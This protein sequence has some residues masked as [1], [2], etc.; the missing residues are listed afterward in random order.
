M[1]IITTR[2][3]YNELSSE[4]GLNI[5]EVE[6]LEKT[7]K[8]LK[9]KIT[10]AKEVDRKSKLESALVK[11][12]ADLDDKKYKPSES[13]EELLTR[14]E[15]QR[16]KDL[17]DEDRQCQTDGGSVEK[18]WSKKKTGKKRLE[19]VKSRKLVHKGYNWQKK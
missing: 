15:Q 4:I 12:E 17:E 10:A 6:N 5:N 11:A 3:I 8:S 19:L 9:R 13:T 18:N 2:K 7:I 1:K 14:V 16:Q